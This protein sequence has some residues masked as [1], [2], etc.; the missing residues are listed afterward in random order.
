MAMG[1]SV[2]M[3]TAHFARRLQYSSLI[4]VIVFR[5]TVDANILQRSHL[6]KAKPSLVLY[7]IWVI[8]RDI[9]QINISYKRPSC[10]SNRFMA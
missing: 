2:T 7:L 5:W 4:I 1:Q 8:K 9:M 10:G 6:K 3:T